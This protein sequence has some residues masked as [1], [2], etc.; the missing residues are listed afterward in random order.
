MKKIGLH[1]AILI[2]AVILY[3]L[4]ARKIINKFSP[5]E[6]TL[7]NSLPCNSIYDIYLHL[8]AFCLFVITLIFLGARLYKNYHNR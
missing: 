1:I 5:C 6:D 8:F 7:I 2:L 3:L 4:P